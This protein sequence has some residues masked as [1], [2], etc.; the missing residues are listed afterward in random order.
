MKKLLATS[1]FIIVLAGC[2]SAPSQ[3]GVKQATFDDY[4]ST[5]QLQS[6]EKITAFKF[7]GWRS[8]DSEHLII[9][10]SPKRPYLIALQSR[11]SK[12]KH[13][14][15]IAIN[16]NG[17]NTLQAGFDSITVPKFPGHKCIIKSIY[18]LT[19]EQADEVSQ[20]AKKQKA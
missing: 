1:L 15:G 7:Q 17:T 4:V 8:L 11:C 13:A 20:L 2:A 14:R 10:T 5:H 16:S 18:R 3:S 19:N 9:T 12:L 6:L